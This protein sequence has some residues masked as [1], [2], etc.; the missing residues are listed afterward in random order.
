MKRYVY[1]TDSRRDK[2]VITF[3]Q[4][5]LMESHISLLFVIQIKRGFSLLIRKLSAF[6]G[7]DES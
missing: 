7:V 6:I 1:E 4:S 2:E 5:Q 3:L